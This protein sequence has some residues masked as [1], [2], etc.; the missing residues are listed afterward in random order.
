MNDIKHEKRTVKV[1]VF[2][3]PVPQKWENYDIE[4]ISVVNMEVEGMDIG[5][6]LVAELEV[7]HY[8]ESYTH[9]L[10]DKVNRL[11]RQRNQAQ[12]KVRKYRRKYNKQQERIIQAIVFLFVFTVVG[13][14][15][16]EIYPHIL[17]VSQR[18]AGG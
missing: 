10:E 1:D 3:L 7:S 13:I 9:F 6:R 2:D 16:W 4:D 12:N 17:E 15:M 18:M 8:Q 11:E 14:I 5:W